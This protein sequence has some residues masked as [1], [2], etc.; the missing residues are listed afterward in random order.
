MQTNNTQNFSE[1]ENIPLRYRRELLPWWVRGF[2]WM[3]I[4]MGALAVP[5]FVSLFFAPNF[6]SSLFDLD[7]SVPNGKFI[8]AVLFLISG[9][10]GL[11]LWLEKKDAV[12][13]AIICGFINLIASSIS[14]VLL[15]INGDGNL[16]L[17]LFICI[18][19]ISKMFQIKNNWENK[20]VSR[21]DLH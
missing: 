9:F 8:S 7:Q 17:E 11:W 6:E 19:F 20:Y 13:I 21:K 5:G 15:I 14:M 3:F 1:F 12:T 4:V 2:S 10:T 16:P 18:L